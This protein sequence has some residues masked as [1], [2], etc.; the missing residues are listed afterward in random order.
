VASQ[1][2]AGGEL[3]RRYAQALFELAEEQGALD[4]VAEDLRGLGEMV[5]DSADLRWVLESPV[6]SRAEQEEAVRAVADKAGASGIVRNILSLR[7]RNR[8]LAILP[9]VTRAYLAELAARRGETVAEITAATALDERQRA[10]VEDALKAALGGKVAIDETTDPGLIGGLVIRVGSK[11][12]DA[13]VK[14][15]LDRLKLA[16]KGVS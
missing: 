1:D 9:A 2:T 7:A 12:V 5:A 3:A 6:L 15:K 16:M 13:S 4:R 10:A 11:M 8:R 14:S